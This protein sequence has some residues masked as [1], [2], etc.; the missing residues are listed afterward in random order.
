MQAPVGTRNH[1]VE[2]HTPP[3]IRKREVGDG[4]IVIAELD[5]KGRGLR[6]SYVANRA[7]APRTRR[8]CG[9]PVSPTGTDRTRRRRRTA[10]RGVSNSP[11]FGP[12]K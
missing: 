5:R 1:P 2:I 4:M 12:G 10:V 11:V 9:R 7:F 6:R 8:P 3:L